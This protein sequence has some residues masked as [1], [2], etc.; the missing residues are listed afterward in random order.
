MKKVFKV[1]TNKY[2]IT[3]VAFIA[4]TVFFDQNDWMTLQQRQHEL[5]GVKDNIA[6]LNTEINRM[7]AERQDLLT[8]GK[9]LETY[10][11]ENYRM[12]H[13]GEDVYVIEK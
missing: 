11:R 12:K 3:S 7:S 2:F 5:N 6:Y 1:I 8:N 4:W 9:K 10:A 13:D